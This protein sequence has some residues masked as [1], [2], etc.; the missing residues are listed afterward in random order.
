MGFFESALG[1]LVMNSQDENKLIVSLFCSWDYGYI[2]DCGT[3]SKVL[4][5]GNPINL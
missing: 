2:F 4:G 1:W 5:I 3:H